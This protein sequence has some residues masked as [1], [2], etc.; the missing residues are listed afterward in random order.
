MI[1]SELDRAEWRFE[2]DAAFNGT[3][4][5]FTSDLLRLVARSDAR[6][7]GLLRQV[8]PEAVAAVEAWKR[9]EFV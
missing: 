2:L 9:G 1:L 6:N 5:W 3:G 7:R 4:D 8:F